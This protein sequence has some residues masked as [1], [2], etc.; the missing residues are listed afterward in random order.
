[1]L[2]G[3]HVFRGAFLLMRALLSPLILAFLF[4]S[5]F[6]LLPTPNKDYSFAIYDKNEKLLCASLS[7]SEE[8]HLPFVQEINPLYK[9]AVIIYEDRA[10]YLHFGFDVSS[11]M[12]AGYLNL[13]NKKIISGASTLTMQVAR[14]L[15]A[16]KTRGYIQKLKELFYALLLEIKYT[17]DEIFLLYASHAPLGGNVVGLEAAAFRYYS[18]SQKDL[19]ASE[20]STLAA[21][22][23]QPSMVTLVNRR[24]RLKEKRDEILKNLC[25]YSFIEKEDYDLS[26]EENLSDSPHP[27]PFL[28]MHYHDMLKKQF[29]NTKKN[30]NDLKNAS[31]SFSEKHITSIDYTLQNTIEKLVEEKAKTL[32][33][34]L[35]FNMAALVLEVE[36]G[37]VLAYVGNS[38]FFAKNGKNVYVDMVAARRSSGSLLK[39]FLYAGMLD[40]GLILPDSLL[41]D[42]PTQIQS[43]APKNNN[44][45]YTG[46]VPASE[47]LARSLNVPFV[48]ALREYGIPPFLRFLKECGFSTLDRSG[49]EYGLPLILGGG[50][51][52]LFESCMAYLA[53]MRRAMGEESEFPISCGAAYLTLDALTHKKMSYQDTSYMGAQKIAWKTGTSDGFKDAWSIGCTQ[54]YVVGVW[55]GNADGAGRPEIRSNIAAVPLMF[56]IFDVLEKHA[57]LPSPMLELKMTKTCTHSGYPASRYCDDTTM[58]PSPIHAP[59]PKL[60]PYCKPV[61]LSEDGKFRVAAEDVIG[62]EKIE[63]RFS[64]PPFE[65]FFYKKNHKQYKSLPPLLNKSHK[66]DDFDII[67]PEAG[68]IIDIPIELSEEMGAFTAKAIHKTSSTTL[69]WDIDGHYLGKTNHFHQFDIRADRGPHILTITDSEGNMKERLFFIK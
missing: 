49:E 53:L 59:L 17:K 41:K 14:L 37:K 56:D 52:T 23:N 27:L 40:R 25:Y 30:I 6:Y 60:C 4:L 29:E 42:V 38:G 35:V 20:I 48:R 5:L 18:S 61:C 12:R 11:I 3:K 69:Y 62:N 24:E 1:M 46:M 15:S 32:R 36:T 51:V 43:Y 63:N 9:K 33:D 65:E 13:K 7:S 2:L 10:F 21:L 28:A 44:G 66:S 45:K 31:N 64:L 57:W 58:T 16:S 22:P 19:T 26:I 55:A 54:K 39:P 50:E 67:F 34:S 68:D 47:A 8:Y